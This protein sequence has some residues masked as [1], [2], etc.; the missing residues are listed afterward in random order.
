MFIGHYSISLALKK[1]EP[2]LSLPLLFIA[3][4]WVD[5]LFFSFTLLGIEKFRLVKNFTAINHL[6]LY[7][8][9]F[10]HSVAAT[11]IWTIIG[12]FILASVS[13]L[14]GRKSPSFKI[15]YIYMGIAVF[16]HFIM[17]LPM[18]T[19]DLPLYSNESYKLGFGLWNYLWPA[20]LFELFFV[21]GSLY[22]LWTMA[23]QKG[24]VKLS[25]WVLIG[26]FLI[27]T[28]LPPFMP[29]PGSVPEMAI[30]GL[31]SYFILPLLALWVERSL[32]VQ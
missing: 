5:I 10:T 2:L 3:V 4:Q 21:V 25:F 12:G 13:A 6:D 26:I 14:I 8:M 17:D 9:P 27:F 32:V 16:S 23:K 7:Y 24:T 29:M 28:L 31:A 19:Q 1:K 15:I 20:L 30:Q 22:L 11:I 18:H